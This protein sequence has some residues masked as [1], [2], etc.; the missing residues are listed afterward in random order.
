M[1]DVTDV[2]DLGSGVIG[3]VECD[4]MAFRNGGLFQFKLA[5]EIDPSASM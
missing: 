4:Y 5:R 3:G 2:K 1:S